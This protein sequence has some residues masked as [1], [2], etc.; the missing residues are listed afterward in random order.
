MQG[1]YAYAPSIYR[2]LR[3]YYYY[4]R[5]VVVRKPRY[6][7]GAYAY[8]P[9]I[10]CLLACQSIIMAEEEEDIGKMS[11]EKFKD[12]EKELEAAR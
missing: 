10:C 9:C 3:A 5:V 11:R 8:A 12:L 6:M 7:L 1:A 2:G 4:Y